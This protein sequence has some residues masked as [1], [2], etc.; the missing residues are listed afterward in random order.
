M[1]VCNGIQTA[2][3]WVTA[4]RA[5]AAWLSLFM[6]VLAVSGCQTARLGDEPIAI[7]TASLTPVEQQAF[8]ALSSPGSYLDQRAQAV[9][10][11]LEQDTDESLEVIAWALESART[12]EVNQAALQGIYSATPA[13]DA[14]PE[15]LWWPLVARMDTLPPSLTEDFALAASRFEGERYTRQLIDWA[16]SA[17]EP[18]PVRRRAIA[19]LGQRRTKPVA[20]VLVQ[21]TDVEQAPAVRESAY[22]ALGTLTGITAFGEDRGAWR[23]WWDE[24]RGLDAAGWNR[25]LA[26][27]FASR[28]PA[29]DITNDQLVDRIRELNIAMHRLASPEDK[30]R[31]LTDLL[32]EE[33]MPLRELGLSLA[34]QRL[35]AA[36]AFDEPLLAALRDNLTV[37]RPDLRQRAAV[38]LRDL[39]DAPSA[40]IVADRLKSNQE[41]VDAVLRAYL[42]LLANQPRVEAV[43]AVQRHLD[44]AAV[45]SQAA[46]ALAAAA[47]EGMVRGG[48]KSRVARTARQILDRSPDRPDPAVITLL[49]RVGTNDDFARIA[50]WLD[51]R[52]ATVRR[53]A[54]Q[55]W[56]DSTRTLVPLAERADDSVVQPIVITSAERRGEDP[57]TMRTLALFPPAAD[58]PAARPAWGRALVAM[59]GRVPRDQSLAAVQAITDPA[60]TATR[61]A[62]VTA[63]LDTQPPNTTP[64][65]AYLGLLLERAELR[66][67]DARPRLAVLD[68]EA[69]VP[70][71][72]RLTGTQRERLQRGLIRAALQTDQLDKAFAVAR[73]L[74]EGPNGALIQPA[75]DDP[76]IELFVDAAAQHVDQGRRNQARRVLEELRLLLGPAMKPQVALRIRNVEERALT[77]NPPAVRRDTDT[78]DTP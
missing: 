71:Q 74:F 45:Q 35:S 1:R 20:E 3:G 28:E 7:D 31:V 30:P 8:A 44:D 13:V 55:A 65:A 68:F 46:A 11:L 40:D 51:A 34:E 64:D 63:G 47:N 29:R 9:A 59:A 53:A 5:T 26:E 39:G 37:D 67:D 48:R 15:E 72:P 66:L 62:V 49:G 18:G 73:K 76:V 22:A 24:V 43:E 21:L 56:A 17:E 41:H 32:R 2:A 23:Q 61:E 54:A 27:N 38:L 33:L 78:D 6:L 52:D 57:Q 58:Q 42:L 25:Q 75:N 12:A 10:T 60:L 36:E 16:R 4:S 70:Y 19:A 14:M 77:P 69:L 50:G